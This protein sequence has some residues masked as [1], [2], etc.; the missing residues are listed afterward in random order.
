MSI[1]VAAV[2]ENGVLKPKQPLPLK[3]HEEVQISI[4]PQTAPPPAVNWVDETYGM[5]RWTGSHAELDR[6]ALD[7]S[8]DPQD[9]P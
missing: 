5:I 8:L 9:A 4:Q 3:E 7:P 1:T 2:Y 6:F